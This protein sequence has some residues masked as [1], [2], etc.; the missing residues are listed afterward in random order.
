LPAEEFFQWRKKVLEELHKTKR[1]AI[2]ID[3]PIQHNK[4]LSE[5][6]LNYFV[7]S[8]RYVTENI[9]IDNIHVFLTGGATASAM[10]RTLEESTLYVKEEILPGV[11]SLQLQKNGRDIGC[12]TVKPGSY[13]W[14]E[15]LTGHVFIQ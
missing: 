15:S 1:V 10:I 6:F 2:T 13:P 14:P 8:F 9:A 12:F 4:L 3:H 7:E 5:M 11:V